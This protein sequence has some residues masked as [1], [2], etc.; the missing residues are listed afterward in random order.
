MAARKK[1]KKAGGGKKEKKGSQGG[2]LE[3]KLFSYWKKGL[4]GEFVTAFLRHRQRATRTE[5]ASL[6]DRAVYRLLDRILF[7]DRKPSLLEGFLPQLREDSGLSDETRSCLDVAQATYDLFRGEAS[8]EQ[9]RI[10]PSDLPASFRELRDYLSGIPDRAAESPLAE[11]AE[12]RRKKAR[13]GEKHFAAAARVSQQLQ[14]LDGSSLLQGSITPLTRMR[15]QMEEARTAA[16]GQRGSSS[17]ALRDAEA[18]LQL[19]RELK[20]CP[21]DL[22]EARYV[23]LRLRELGMAYSPHPFP[24]N[25]LRLVLRLGSRVQGKAWERSLRLCLAPQDPELLSGLPEHAVQQLAL[26]GKGLT[27]MGQEAKGPVPVL[28]ALLGHDVWSRRERIVMLWGELR[29]LQDLAGELTRS[30]SSLHLELDEEELEG[31]QAYTAHTIFENGLELFPL[32]QELL[33][34]RSEAFGRATQDWIA[35]AAP[36]PAPREREE[37]TGFTDMALRFPLESPAWLLLLMRSAETYP[38]QNKDPV[39]TRI[40]KHLAPLRLEEGEIPFAADFLPLS[41]APGETLKRWGLCLEPGSLRAVSEQLAE[42]LFHKTVA[43]DRLLPLDVWTRTP[44]ALMREL[45]RSVGE[46]FP[47][48]GLILYTANKQNPSTPLP[49][50]EEE[51]RVFLDRLPPEETLYSVL[52]WM[53][54]FSPTPPSASFL[55]QMIRQIADYATRNQVWEDIACALREH[56]S[57]DLAFRVWSLWEELGLPDFLSENEDFSDAWRVLRPLAFRGKQAPRR[58]KVSKKKG[59]P[60]QKTLPTGKAQGKG[61]NRDRGNT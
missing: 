27:Y 15:K 46:D 54:D 58:R 39:L 57:Q 7:R 22:A 35:A 41:H 18:L 30:F 20:S 23:F 28:S 53:L 16:E 33:P 31:I 6:W 17:P 51:A 29:A 13:S 59:H 56:G 61:T 12:Q 19:L 11:Y 38:S 47:L 40:Q 55:E 43:K 37:L 45:A 4:Y 2:R 21:E 60:R 42:N 32:I 52:L 48:R 50:S 9:L 8:Q 26:L 3:P 14:E 5:A 44:Q 1:G 10:L 36:L 25:L 34:G 24:R 49:T